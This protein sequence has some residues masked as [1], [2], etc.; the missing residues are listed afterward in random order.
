MFFYRVTD[1][2][3]IFS[4]SLENEGNTAVEAFLYLPMLKR[5]ACTLSNGR[6][7]LLN[8]DS[9]P[10]T[11]T[12][13]E[14]TFVMTELGSNSVITCMCYLN[15]E[16]EKVCELWCGQSE[17]QISI[18]TIKDQ[19]VIAQENLNHYQ[20]VIHNVQVKKLVSDGTAVWSYIHPGCIVYQW[21]PKLRSIVNKLDCSKLVPCSESLKSIAIE[22]HLSPTNCQV[23]PC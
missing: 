2:Y 11:P 10:K 22:E 8:S 18:Y 13:A 21:D 19:G 5:V 4:Y 20:P 12:A 17:A 3:K 16:E 7:F 6:L 15:I 14:G 1:G 23:C 9:L